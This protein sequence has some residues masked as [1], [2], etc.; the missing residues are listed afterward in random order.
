MNIEDYAKRDA[1][2][3][4]ALVRRGEVQPAE[5]A[6]AAMAACEEVNPVLNAVVETWPDDVAAQLGVMPM[7][8]PLAGAPFLIKD[9]SQFRSRGPFPLTSR[10]YAADFAEVQAVG[11]ATSTTRSSGAS[12]SSATLAKSAGSSASS[13]AG[14]GSVGSSARAA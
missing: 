12:R 6:A 1:I 13:T 10:R 4:A 8:A 5:V 11:S 14:A 7:G 3:L 9:A 2:G